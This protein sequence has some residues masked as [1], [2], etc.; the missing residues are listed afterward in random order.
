MDL[1]PVPRTN[2][3]FES[4]LEEPIKFIAESAKESKED[5]C[6]EIKVSDSVPQLEPISVKSEEETQ[7]CDKNL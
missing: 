3:N 5:S 2:K 1:T 4:M 6:N 7:G